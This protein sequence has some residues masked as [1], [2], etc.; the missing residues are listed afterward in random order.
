VRDQGKQMLP[1]VVQDWLRR[2]DIER[3]LRSRPPGWRFTGVPTERLALYERDLRAAVG[4]ARGAGAEIVL[5]THASRFIGAAT[6]DEHQLNAWE[7][8]YPRA[9]G[10]V[11]LD[12]EAAADQVT[13]RVASD[14]SVAVVDVAG[15]LAGGGS[16]LFADFSHFTDAGAARV[17]GAVAGVLT[18]RLCERA[19]VVP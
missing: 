14:S 15:A 2:G 3:Q 10:R 18:P 6:L 13:R 9:P 5:A 19:R 11:I 8:Y 16:A 7:R 1:A 17:A 4:A 12:F